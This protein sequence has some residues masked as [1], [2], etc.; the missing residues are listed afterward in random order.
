[1]A[2]ESKKIIKSFIRKLKRSSFV[3][4]EDAYNILVNWPPHTS[5]YKISKNAVVH[6]DADHTFLIREIMLKFITRQKTYSL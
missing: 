1:M 5:I 6:P 4:S 3:V 2:D